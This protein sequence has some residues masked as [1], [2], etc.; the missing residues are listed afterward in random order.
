MRTAVLGWGSLIWATG[1]L[2]VA[3]G[4]WNPDGPLLPIEFV[5]VSG[6][7]TSP[8]LTLV[9]TDLPETRTVRTLWSLSSIE[10]FDKA[11]ADLALR[12]D[13]KDDAR[14]GFVKRGVGNIEARARMQAVTGETRAALLGRIDAWLSAPGH[15]RIEA[16]IWTDLGRNTE[17]AKRISD[18]DQAIAFLRKLKD[19]QATLAREYVEKA[20][21]QVRT[22]GRERIETELGWMPKP[23]APAVVS[24]DDLRF[25]EWSECRTTVG[26]FDT[27]LEDLRKYGFSI[28]TGLLA[29]SSFLSFFGVVVTSGLPAPYIEVRTAVFA[30]IISLIAALFF[31]DTYYEVLLSAAV[32]RALDIETLTDPGVRL[33]KYL[34]YN[35]LQTG[36]VDQTK[37]M[38]Y[39]LYWTAAALA[40]VML[41]RPISGAEASVP[42]A[43]A[44]SPPITTPYVLVL[45]TAVVFALYA[46]VLFGVMARYRNGADKKTGLNRGKADRDW[47]EGPGKGNVP[48]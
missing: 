30:A 15:E 46:I 13:M 27:I 18:L 2:H 32:E 1:S 10:D 20:P 45:A 28:I 41:I 43:S 48:V 38:Y 33:S 25:K 47:R 23:V 11:V 31:V 39:F 12:E 42:G 29:A 21:A 44:G 16:V 40:G 9:V 7:D 17:A 4:L 8:R 14:V 24:P 34:S 5:R 22:R 3:N 36:A 35:A 26:R 19:D 37:H 6:P